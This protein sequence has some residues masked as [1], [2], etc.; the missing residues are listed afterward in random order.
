MVPYVQGKKAWEHDQITKM[1]VEKLKTPLNIAALKYKKRSYK[2]LADQ[3]TSK[4]PVFSYWDLAD[5]KMMRH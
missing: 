1:E 5:Y 3:L 2:K 4:D